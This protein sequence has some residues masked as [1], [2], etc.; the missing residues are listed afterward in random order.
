[1]LPVVV[2]VVVLVV[3]VVVEVVVI[4]VV[5]SMAAVVTIVVFSSDLFCGFGGTLGSAFCGVF[6]ISFF[7]RA[8]FCSTGWWSK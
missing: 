1:M 3:V 2:L 5:V 6:G 4:V 8:F 7:G